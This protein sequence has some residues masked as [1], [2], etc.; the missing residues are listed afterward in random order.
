MCDQPRRSSHRALAGP[1]VWHWHRA[2][3]LAHQRRRGELFATGRGQ[4]GFASETGE[5]VTIMQRVREPKLLACKRQRLGFDF[6]FLRVW[7]LVQ[8]F[9]RIGSLKRASV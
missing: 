2:Q 6:L 8:K 3:R 1:V 4:D 5:V 9:G 7:T